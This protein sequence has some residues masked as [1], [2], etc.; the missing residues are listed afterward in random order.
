[1]TEVA[2]VELPGPTSGLQ[3]LGTGTPGSW[4]TP[5]P[6][7]EDGAFVRVAQASFFLSSSETVSALSLFS[8]FP[9]TVSVM[10]AGV[11]ALQLER[12]RAGSCGVSV[13]PD[14]RT[15]DADRGGSWWEAREVGA[16]LT[17]GVPLP[18]GHLEPVQSSAP[19]L[20]D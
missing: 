9:G 13:S 7:Q 18:E 10:K 15:G 11:P 14:H 16:T 6:L 1:M 12:I 17:A 20:Q 4:Q 2:M 5:A 19:G 8:S 3:G